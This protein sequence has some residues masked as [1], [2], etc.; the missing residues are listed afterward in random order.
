MTSHLNHQDNFSLEK[1]DGFRSF[2]GDVK[3]VGKGVHRV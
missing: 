2:M 1:K 3:A